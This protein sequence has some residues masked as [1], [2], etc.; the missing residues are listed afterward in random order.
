MPYPV[1]QRPE[2]IIPR[3]LANLR[4]RE[5]VWLDDLLAEWTELAGPRVAPQARPGRWRQ[6]VLT[7]G[8]THS[9]HLS[10]LVRLERKGLLERL[11][12]RFG[13]ARIRDLRF[14]LSA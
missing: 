5:K 1:P 6:G 9:V 2:Q 12:K 13:A 4:P 11:Q 7:I 10:R 3:I 8:V 14:V